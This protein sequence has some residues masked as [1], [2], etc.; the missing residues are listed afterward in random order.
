MILLNGPGKPFSFRKDDPMKRTIP[1]LLVGSV[2]GAGLA[3]WAT[4]ARCE[5]AGA[6]TPPAPVGFAKRYTPTFGE[7]LG[8]WLA[9]NM[10]TTQVNEATL[11][12]MVSGWSWNTERGNLQLAYDKDYSNLRGT[13]AQVQLK[14]E[15]AR[16]FWNDILARIELL[17]RMVSYWQ[18]AGYPVSMDTLDFHIN[19]VK[20]ENYADFK[21]HVK[22]QLRRFI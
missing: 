20:M 5:P 6:A 19:K 4:R 13:T 21:D 3:L 8:L 12:W 11:G 10:N 9:V 16:A 22:G 15:N 18:G 7:W 1:V 17:E 14:R 2:L